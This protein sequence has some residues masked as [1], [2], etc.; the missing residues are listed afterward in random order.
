[1]RLLPF[2]FTL[3]ECCYKVEVFKP[4]GMALQGGTA[5]VMEKERHS[6]VNK[7]PEVKGT[8]ILLKFGLLV[9]TVNSWSCSSGCDTHL[10]E[11]LKVF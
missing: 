6:E 3:S 11:A 7:L 9:N 4:R 2:R 1:M 8:C 5:E 10:M